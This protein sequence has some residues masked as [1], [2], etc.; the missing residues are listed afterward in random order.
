VWCQS[1]EGNR[2]RERELRVAETDFAGRTCRAGNAIC[3]IGSQ[4][5]ETCRSIGRPLTLLLMDR[6]RFRCPQLWPGFSSRRLR[7]LTLLMRGSSSLCLRAGYS[8]T[9][10]YSSTYT[11]WYSS[12]LR[13]CLRTGIW[14]LCPA[15]Y[16]TRSVAAESVVVPIHRWEEPS[17]DERRSSRSLICW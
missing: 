12:A 4:G 6:P 16:S 2:M 1:G 15:R 13:G 17:R 8:C 5:G 7:A 11:S 9:G 14:R 10:Y 3:S